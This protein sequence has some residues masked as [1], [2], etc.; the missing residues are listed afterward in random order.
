MKNKLSI[1]IPSFNRPEMLGDLIESINR[2]SAPVKE[3]EIVICEDHSPKRFEIRKI[4]EQWQKKNRYRIKYFEN[5]EN[6]GYDK[7]LRE[8]ISK[9]KGEYMMF[10]G[11]DDFVLPENLPAFVEFLKSLD[12][13]IAYILRSYQSIHPDGKIENYKYYPETIFFDKGEKTYIHLFRKSVSISGFTFR[14]EYGEGLATDIFDGTLLY[15]IYLMSELVL[16]HRAVYYDQPLVR[17]RQSFREDN[18]FFGHSKNEKN[19]FTAGKV[20][21]RNSINFMKGYI[22]IMDFL[23]EKYKM[24]AKKSILDDFS[25]YSYPVLSIQRKHGIGE[26]IKYVRILNREIKINT[27]I[28]YYIYIIALIFFGE[29]FSDN[30]IY[31]IKKI[32]G[33]TPN[34]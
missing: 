26:F 9:A 17:I 21:I 13:D 16:N 28:Y 19:F 31:F 2:S 18:A 7:N 10:M 25:R 6:L 32:F 23:D 29:K 8:L 27:T 5:K 14:K 24:Q 22:K 20:T 12:N 4:V 1:C 34:L 11:D 3:I 33:R 30:I 15:Q